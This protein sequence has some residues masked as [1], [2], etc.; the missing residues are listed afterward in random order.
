MILMNL[1]SC[2]II[3]INNNII[4]VV[5]FYPNIYD[6]KNRLLIFSF[7]FF[8]SFILLL[9]LLLL[10]YEYMYLY[11]INMYVCFIAFGQ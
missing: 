5:G 1:N 2:F 8:F 9:L 11:F 4:I 7:L 10:Y 3:A 6:N